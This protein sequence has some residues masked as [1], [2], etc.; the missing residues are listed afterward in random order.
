MIFLIKLRLIVPY[1]KIIFYTKEK[2]FFIEQ[3]I[4]SIFKTHKFALL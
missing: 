1:N 4:G 2:N 3:N